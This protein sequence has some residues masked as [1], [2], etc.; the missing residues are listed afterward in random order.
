MCNYE[1]WNYQ[2]DYGSK[3]RERERE[4][5]QV[6]LLKSAHDCQKQNL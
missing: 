2:K 4:R 3:E 6:N 5:L 1:M